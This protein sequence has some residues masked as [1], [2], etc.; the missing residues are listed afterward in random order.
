MIL[1]MGK[2]SLLKYEKYQKDHTNGNYNLAYISV[3]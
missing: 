3:F 2:S 1:Y